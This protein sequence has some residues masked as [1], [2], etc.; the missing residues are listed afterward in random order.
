MNQAQDITMPMTPLE[1]RA[2]FSLALIFACRMLGLFM[3][4]P[5]FSLY[6][7]DLPNATPLLIGFAISAYGL[8][9]A[10]LQIPFGMLSDHFGRKKIIA[11]GLILFAAGSVLAALSDSIY[12]IIAGRALQGCG[13]IA[14]AVM[15]LAADLTREEH[16]TKAMA[17]IGISIGISFAIA[18]VAGPV[19]ASAIGISGIF[20][21]TAGL[22]L[23]AFAVLFVMVPSPAK[24]SFH[25]D[26]EPVPGQFHRVLRNSELLRL[27]VGILALHL[28]L[29]ATF[30]TLPLVL[31]DAGV[32]S[33]N[34]WLVYL[35]VMVVAI[36]AMVPFVIIAEKK[37]K[38]KIVFLGAITVI[39]IS[40]LGLFA[41]HDRL[42]F[43][44]GFLFLF[45][46]G[47]N[48]LEATLPSMISKIAPAGA[49]GTAMGV[50]SSSQFI[51]AF[52]GGISGGWIY[53][54]FGTE[55]VFLFCCAVALLWL[56]VAW[57]MR[58]PLHVSRL[59]LNIGTIDPVD[60]VSIE[61]K[62]AAIT[63]VADVSVSTA[64]GIVYLKVDQGKLDRES[65]DQL[66]DYHKV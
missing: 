36:A 60:A 39:A 51:G 35:P 50:Y 8:T 24:L 27:D 65:L 26:T 12:G 10:L 62:M 14:A 6:A 30:V 59:L 44:V 2:S 4:L 53:G 21:L 54:R 18:L 58:P 40:G 45:F 5:V 55:E 63:G 25:S 61:K 38:M 43:I 16:R 28:M 23:A 49:K 31:R 20:W 32:A 3:I 48:L 13:A 9:Q 29:T 41:F 57:G 11:L 56:L 1:R 64:E 33:V 52:L 19:I 15:A 66:V 46:T 37:R 7:E 22:A 34:H 17:S 42:A 47:F